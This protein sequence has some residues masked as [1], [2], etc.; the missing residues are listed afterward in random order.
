[1][2]LTCLLLALVVLSCWS[3]RAPGQDGDRPERLIF[4]G[5]SITQAGARPQGYI[6]L[7]RN[8]MKKEHPNLDLE[9]IGAGISGNKVP[10]LQRR[11]QRDV[12][13]KEP[14]VVVIYIGINDVWHSQSG[15]GTSKKDYRAGLQ[16]II[17]KIQSAGGRVVVCTPSVIG[18]KTDGTN[19]LDAMLEEYSEISR[20]VAGQTGCQVIDLRKAFLKHLKSANQQNA[21]RNVL[22]SDGVHLN[23][24]G[25]QFVADQMQK[26]LKLGE[27]HGAG[28]GKLQHVV[29]FRFNENVDAAGTEAIVQEFGKL[30]GKID[31]IAAYEFGSSIGD[32]KMAQQMTHCFLVTFHSEEDLQA[33]L[34]HPA[35]LEFVKFLDG[36]IEKLL[37]FDYWAK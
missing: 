36:K 18:E 3:L 31:E 23:T 7:F 12:L 6:S 10:D 5:D 2:K 19:S 9:V 1:M 17:S 8:A 30:P 21:E 16:D 11:L 20:Q 27:T 26:G 25:N 15:R 33:Y 32:E 24:A 14:T 37:V 13:D 22:T 28:D 29:M 35:H 4:L 34:V